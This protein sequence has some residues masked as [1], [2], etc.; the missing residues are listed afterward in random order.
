MS[1][2][3][4][5]FLLV[6]DQIVY[7]V[8]LAF[9]FIIPLIV[10]PHPYVSATFVKI[11]VLALA[12]T[13]AVTTW[14]FKVLKKGAID[15]Q[16]RWFVLALGVMPIAVL[17]STFFGLDTSNGVFGIGTSMLTFYFVALG[18]LLIYVVATT[19]NTKNRMFF[20]YVALLSSAAILFIFH[21]IR[22]LAG[23]DSLTL[24]VFTSGSANTIGTWSD[25]GIFVASIVLL[26]CATLEYLP[27]KKAWKALLWTLLVVG[28]IL[29]AGTNFNVIII[30]NATGIYLSVFVGLAALAI[31]AHVFTRG[32]QNLEGEAK[33]IFP[34][35][36]FIVVIVSA[37]FT[38]GAADI[39]Q[40]MYSRAQITQQELVDIRM[41]Q[42]ATFDLIAETYKGG[43]LQTV[44]GS[45]PARMETA[46]AMYKPLDV[47]Q[48]VF[49]DSEVT[50]ASGYLT[51][52]FI[53]T[54]VLGVLAILYVFIYTG[55]IA[56][57]YFKIKSKDDYD[58]YFGLTSFGIAALIWISALFYVPSVTIIVLGC[59]MLGLFYAGAI[60]EGVITSTSKTLPTMGGKGMGIAAVSMI[61]II[62][63]ITAFYGWSQRLAASMNA[64][65]AVVIYS[66]D[67]NVVGAKNLLVK[68]I[69]N[70]PADI[71]LRTLAGI[72]LEEVA[73][74]LKGKELTESSL[75]DPI[76]I[77]LSQAKELGEE[78]VRYNPYSY[79]NHLELGNTYEILSQ[80][81]G[82]DY[83]FAARDQ[84]LAAKQ[85]NPKNPV[86]NGNLARIYYKAGEFAA[87]EAEI[88]DALQKKPDLS[89]LNADLAE[90]RKQLKGKP[91]TTATSTKPATTSTST[92][93]N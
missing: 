67:K 61:L 37:I 85:L 8:L 50:Y 65:N 1:R 75:T 32:N 59:F 49:W 86:P 84:Y 63:V 57:R 91:A 10:I 39:S 28:L 18:A 35:A 70:Y 23:F 92:V 83:A 43:F 16:S 68:A 54:G 12:V 34:T 73:N 42:G 79:Q 30:N 74:E 36:S 14:F 13:I 46:W 93:K 26:A 24:G 7:G 20:G 82:S 53:T 71:Y 78:A 19:F 66:K 11:G 21:G 81:L 27:L 76:R 31:C 33:R 17:L 60:R 69:T 44:F 45:G 15:G 77:S 90:I 80:L 89:Q 72:N 3:K 40:Y 29:L 2:I 58:Y 88:L 51:T 87:A 22:M 47:N 52:F 64:N 62:L 48:S 6:N 38:M 41:T 4:S 25:M 9:L 56:Y 5:L 55:I